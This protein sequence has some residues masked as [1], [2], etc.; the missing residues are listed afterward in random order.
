MLQTGDSNPV[1]IKT[2][3]QVS[4]LMNNGICGGR[5]EG[6]EGRKDRWRKRGRRGK[7]MK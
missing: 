1:D 7:K 3:L 5:E 2:Y 4:W 6:R